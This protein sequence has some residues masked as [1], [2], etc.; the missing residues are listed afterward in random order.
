[1]DG[2]NISQAVVEEKVRPMDEAHYL[3]NHNAD[4]R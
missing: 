2:A 3:E 4:E 1:M